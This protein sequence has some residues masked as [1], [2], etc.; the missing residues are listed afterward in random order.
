M[1]SLLRKVVSHN[2]RRF[3]DGDFDL[4]LSYV[5]D[6]LIAMAYP[7]PPG[8]GQVLI[9]NEGVMVK[10]FLER[11]HAGKY[12]VYNLCSESHNR[13][14]GLGQFPEVCAEI[15][16]ADHHPPRIRQ[17]FKFCEEVEAWLGQSAEHVV[18]VHC[19]AGKG[20]TGSMICAYLMFKFGYG[21]EEVMEFYGERR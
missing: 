14:D 16:M 20:R 4:D 7:A 21:V 19:K 1:A 3:K 2:R 17:M 9:R 15:T 8:S 12:K 18:A 6:Q 5:T 11:R 13:Y 10:R